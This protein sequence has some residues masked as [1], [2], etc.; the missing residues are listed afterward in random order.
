[1]RLPE[2]ETRHATRAL[3]LREGSRLELCDGRGTV[4]QAE[5]ADIGLR[6]GAMARLVGAP[7]QVLSWR[8]AGPWS[9]SLCHCCRLALAAA[10]C[11]PR[12]LHQ[13]APK[14]LMHTW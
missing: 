12:S 8:V 11:L 3:R 2:E 9:C 5:L 14:V 13:Q 6:Q 4:A 10:A 7:T 1:M